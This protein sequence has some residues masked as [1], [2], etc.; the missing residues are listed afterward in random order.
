MKASK[1]SWIEIEGCG[2]VAT[3]E[4]PQQLLSPINLFIQRLKSQGLA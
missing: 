3:T 2:T 4:D 1:T